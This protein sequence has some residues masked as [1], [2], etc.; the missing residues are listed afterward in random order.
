MAASAGA[1]TATKSHAGPGAGAISLEAAIKDR[2]CV[3]D[4]SSAE[5]P[6]AALSRALDLAKLA[7]SAGNLQAFRVVLVRER[8]QKLALAAAALDQDF[9]A[10]A[11]VVAVFLADEDASAQKY[12]TRGARLYAVQDATIAAAFFELTLV[13]E[14]L[15]SSWVGAFEEA[16]VAEVVGASGTALRPVALLPL[17]FPDASVAPPHRGHRRKLSDFVSYNSV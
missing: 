16:T 1:T 4:F 14:G 6:A 13:G 5:V 10:A 8:A 7:P 15:A 9:V 2:H 11:P 12:G 3:R 17:G